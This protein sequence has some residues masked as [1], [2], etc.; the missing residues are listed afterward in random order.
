MLIELRQH[1]VTI[2]YEITNFFIDYINQVKVN[3]IYKQKQILQKLFAFVTYITRIQFYLILLLPAL[4]KV[5]SLDLP[6][7]FH[8]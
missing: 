7:K 2:R 1:V 4:Y 6:K 5:Q 3:K 8:L